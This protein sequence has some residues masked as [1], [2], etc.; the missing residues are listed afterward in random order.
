MGSA[1]QSMTSFSYLDHS[2]CRL[3]EPITFGTELLMYWIIN[4]QEH[5]LMIEKSYKWLI[6]LPWLCLHFET[7]LDKCAHTYKEQKAKSWMKR[8]S[9][10]NEAPPPPFCPI[11]NMRL[12][13]FEFSRLRRKKVRAREMYT[14]KG[15]SMCF[16]EICFKSQVFF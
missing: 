8:W 9:S 7:Q 14:I 11:S 2:I 12:N 3:K 6:H 5:N 4:K 10:G 1:L 15:E 16:R 13:V